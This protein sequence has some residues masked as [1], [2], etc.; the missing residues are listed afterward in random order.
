MNEEKWGENLIV[1]IKENDVNLLAKT[2]L[3]IEKDKENLIVKS[4]ILRDFKY[5]PNPKK[6]TDEIVDDLIDFG[7]ALNYTKQRNISFLELLNI[8]LSL[9]LPLM[10]YY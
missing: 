8:I 5:V 9:V 2:G 4:I 3:F 10:D 7:D 1:V 6:N